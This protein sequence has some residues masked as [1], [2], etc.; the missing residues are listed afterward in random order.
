M[1]R[2]RR[3]SYHSDGITK[4]ISLQQTSATW[5]K[6][7]VRLLPGRVRRLAYISDLLRK[8]VS[9]R[10]AAGDHTILA[11]SEISALGTGLIVAK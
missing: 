2:S 5:V 9:V 4:P 10:D 6:R 1:V 7:G 3:E 8:A 11:F